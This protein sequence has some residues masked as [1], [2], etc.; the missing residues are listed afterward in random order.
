[1]NNGDG[2]DFFSEVKRLVV[3]WIGTRTQLFS[4]F[5]LHGWDFRDAGT[6]SDG[7]KINFR[8]TFPERQ[9]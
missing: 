6:G 9:F 8:T 5:L 7:S 4:R 3:K 2:C 1:M